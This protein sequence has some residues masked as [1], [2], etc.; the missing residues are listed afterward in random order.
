[1]ELS[2]R[3]TG[4]GHGVDKSNVDYSVFAAAWNKRSWDRWLGWS[5]Q[6]QV[7]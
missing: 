1:M 6:V 7:E 5:V 3:P 2:K 4:P